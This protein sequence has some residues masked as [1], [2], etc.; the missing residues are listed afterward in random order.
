MAL[1]GCDGTVSWCCFKEAMIR[2]SAVQARRADSPEKLRPLEQ[3]R[4]EKSAGEKISN[5]QGTEE[6]VSRTTGKQ[7]RARNRRFRQRVKISIEMGRNRQGGK[8]LC[9]GLI[10]WIPGAAVSC[11]TCSKS[12]TWEGITGKAELTGSPGQRTA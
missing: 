7:S 3:N 4:V 9:P 8:D 1:S 2:Q 5:Q 10:G 6:Q 11:L 12:M